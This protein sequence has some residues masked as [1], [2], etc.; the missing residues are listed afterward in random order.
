MQSPGRVPKLSAKVPLPRHATAYHDST[1]P[2]VLLSP[3][4]ASALRDWALTLTSGALGTP[5][6]Q[7]HG[8]KPVEDLGLIFW[9]KGPRCTP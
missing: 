3:R 5:P 7:L 4:I 1:S 8:W 9:P 2:A 6:W